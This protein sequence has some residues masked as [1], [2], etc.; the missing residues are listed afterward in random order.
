MGVGP[1]SWSPKCTSLKGPLVSSRWSLFRV[2]WRA[3]GGCWRLRTFWL[4]GSRRHFPGGK[5]STVHQKR[6]RKVCRKSSQARNHPSRNHPRLQI[7]PGLMKLQCRSDLGF[8]IIS[9]RF[10]CV[11]GFLDAS[12]L[13]EALRLNFAVERHPFFCLAS[14][15]LLRY[16]TVFP[17]ATQQPTFFLGTHASA[18]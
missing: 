4:V 6:Y 15:F 12:F 11:S 13:G 10:L 3:V 1:L 16:H 14:V 18:A 9:Y 2:S 8:G 5:P 7:I 17:G